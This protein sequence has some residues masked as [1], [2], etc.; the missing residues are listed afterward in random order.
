MHLLWH[1]TRPLHEHL[2][3]KSHRDRLEM[4]HSDNRGNGD[5]S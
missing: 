3:A 5:N 4:S 1:W 2:L